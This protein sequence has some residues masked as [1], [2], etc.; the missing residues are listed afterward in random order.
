MRRMRRALAVL[1]LA[2]VVAGCGADVEEDDG[3]ASLPRDTSAAAQAVDRWCADREAEVTAAEMD[4]VRSQEAL[5]RERVTALMDTVDTVTLARIQDVYAIAD[6]AAGELLA[7]RGITPPLPL[8][9]EL[10]EL[11]G[12]LAALPDGS[13]ARRWGERLDEYRALLGRIDE[14]LARGADAS[15]DL[16]AAERL[17][18]ALAGD[19]DGSGVTACR[20]MAV[21]VSPDRVYATIAL[22]AAAASGATDVTGLVAAVGEREPWLGAIALPDRCAVPEIQPGFGVPALA[23]VGVWR[24]PDGAIGVNVNGFEGGTL[25]RGPDGDR[26]TTYELEAV[27]D[28]WRRQSACTP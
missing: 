11:V 1:A 28:H 22:F 23:A 16:G 6:G 3:E 12:R 17:G 25:A 20:A 5:Q 7:E 14:Q 26:W 9:A 10:D 21:E 13:S 24:A 27:D 15:E 4:A 19:A 2:V 8:D 18:T